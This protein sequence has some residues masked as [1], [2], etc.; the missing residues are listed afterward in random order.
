MRGSM[1]L[2][3]PPAPTITEERITASPAAT[4]VPRHILAYTWALSIVLVWLIRSL[5]QE[6]LRMARRA[7]LDAE[8]VLIVGAGDFG[9]RVRHKIAAAPD[10]G[11]RVVG[12]VDDW[13]P[14]TG[15]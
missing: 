3:T 14:G 1:S 10:L 2:T 15:D 9:E 7:G 5:A 6:A 11:Y 13:V 8:R 4:D 12:F